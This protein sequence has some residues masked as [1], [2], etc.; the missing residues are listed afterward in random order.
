ML[1]VIGTILLTAL[2][3]ILAVTLV[4]RFDGHGVT[5]TRVAVGLSAWF[6]VAAWLG[7]TGAF[8]SPALPVGVAVGIAVFAPVILGGGLV[9]RTRGHGI[10]L[11][12]LVGVHIG[13]V[14]GVA[15]LLLYSAGRLPFTL[16]HSAGWGD[17]ATGVLAIPV[18][19]AIQ[20][21]AAG[22]QWLTA[23]WNVLG[24]A[25]LLLAVTLGVGSAPGSLVRFN[26]ETPGSGA[27]VMFPWVLI[28]AFFVPLYL[29][30]HIAIFAH[31]AASRHAA[32]SASH[33]LAGGP[34][35]SIPAR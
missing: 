2:A 35:R 34:A 25:D 6:I 20:R 28:P 13:R 27:I 3:V 4:P 31:L 18:M 29:L 9:A 5:R 12:T 7:A 22:W 16:A 11:T 26:F 15:F 21:R 32:Q 33:P 10:P 1:D 8:A 30:T 17:I 24:M 19:W 23:A 14:L